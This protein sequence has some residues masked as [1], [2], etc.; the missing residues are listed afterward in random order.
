MNEEKEMIGNY[1]VE[2]YM[3]IGNMRYIFARNTDEND[4]YPYMKCREYVQG[5]FAHYDKS[6]ISDDY[7]ELM[8]LHIQDL[9]EAI[10]QL[11]QDRK[12]IGL[13]DVSCLKPDELLPIDYTMNIKGKIVA[14]GERYMIDGQKDI[15]H[16]L[17]Y[18]ERGNGVYAESRGNGC[19]SLN[20]YT[21]EKER[22]ERYEII[23]IVPED[24]LPEFAKKTLEK[25][26]EERE[27]EE[28]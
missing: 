3:R 19:F 25:I 17:Y 8:R 7:I 6:I 22:I 1:A 15:A 24:K 11:E 5:F 14:I 20:L 27:R 10:E 9:S 28:R 21:G 23:G 4:K 26:K 16:Q 13:D 12:A 18:A 2:S